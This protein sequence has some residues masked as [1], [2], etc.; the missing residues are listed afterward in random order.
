MGAF[1]VANLS[2]VLI[3]YTITFASGLSGAFL[4]T[5]TEVIAGTGLQ[6]QRRRERDER[7]ERDEQQNDSGRPEP[8]TEPIHE[9]LPRGVLHTPLV[10]TAG[11]VTKVRLCRP[12]RPGTTAL[13]SKPASGLMSSQRAGSV[14]G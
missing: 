6:S 11:F 8:A 7:D 10:P 3:G 9:L 4:K 12:S 13:T 14:R 1:A 5:E 2:L